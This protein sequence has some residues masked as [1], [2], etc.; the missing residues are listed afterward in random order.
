MS[1]IYRKESGCKVYNPP[2]TGY[3][4]I[5]DKYF[6]V[7]EECAESLLYLYEL[8][9]KKRPDI[10]GWDNL[11]TIADTIGLPIKTTCYFLEKHGKVRDGLFESKGLTSKQIR[12]QVAAAKKKVS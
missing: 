5:N 7:R 6:A 10:F 11:I 3:D 1:F 8:E 2:L 12:Q 9:R 4:L